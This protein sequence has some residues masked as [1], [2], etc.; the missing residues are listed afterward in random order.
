[1]LS[2]IGG[3]GPQLAKELGGLPIAPEK[4][5]DAITALL[6]TDASQGQTLS[7]LAAAVQAQC[8]TELVDNLQTL[9]S[10]VPSFDGHVIN[11]ANA[12]FG[13]CEES[14][15]LG[16]IGL[17]EVLYCGDRLISI[18]FENR[19]LYSME[20]PANAGQIEGTDPSKVM[21][22]GDRIAWTTLSET[23]ASGL[24][25]PSFT[26]T[27]TTVAATDLA[28]KHTITVFKD[29][30]SSKP[31][32]FEI[33][34]AGN[35]YLVVSQSCEKNPQFV[36]YRAADLSAA[37]VDLSKGTPAQ[38]ATDPPA[39]L[40]RLQA[41][42][43]DN[44]DQDRY[45]YLDMR[46]NSLVSGLKLNLT[47]GVC[48]S[49]GGMD[50]YDGVSKDNWLIVADN[51][52]TIRGG[53]TPALNTEELYYKVGLSADGFLI[54][55][56]GDLYLERFDGTRGWSINQDV[57]SF[58]GYVAGL[59]YMRNASGQ[60]VIV[61]PHTGKEE[62][63]PLADV[64]TNLADSIQ[65]GD[66]TTKIGA[67]DTG[68]SILL[69]TNITNGTPKTM[70]VVQRSTACTPATVPMASKPLTTGLIAEKH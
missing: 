60:T 62:H 68:D 37:P 22:S 53:W 28:D 49:V 63:S 64:I 67:I 58:E 43:H 4:S 25:Q 48:G 26:G 59:I 6:F 54:N 47:D 16:W 42:V 57:A 10:Q 65:A 30:K 24:D 31:P 46:S 17:T 8:G 12:V 55:S 50:L 20:V 7:T 18:D 14:D 70:D 32:C 9:Q 29:H 27:V 3:T 41:L 52:T 23:P 11:Q 61:N 56:Q 5:K 66:T 39:S 36:M 35:G 69:G 34:A 38:A 15:P 44:T 51:G 1:M 45:Y 13:M 19:K 40:P 2:Q 21:F 33:Q